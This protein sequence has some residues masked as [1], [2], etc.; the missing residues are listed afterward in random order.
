MKKFVSFLASLA[1]VGVLSSS[2]AAPA[3]S[4]NASDESGSAVQAPMCGRLCILMGGDCCGTL[5]C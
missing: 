2:S 5:C 3:A 1:V 4:L